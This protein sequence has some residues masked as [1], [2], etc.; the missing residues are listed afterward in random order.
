MCSVTGLYPVS[1]IKDA[2]NGC[3]LFLDGERFLD[4]LFRPCVM[5]NSSIIIDKVYLKDHLNDRR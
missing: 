1:Q 2:A 3:D 4:I 5:T